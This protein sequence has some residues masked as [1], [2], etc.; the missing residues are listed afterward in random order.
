M[1]EGCCEIVSRRR[2]AVSIS[3]TGGATA[4]HEEVIGYQLLTFLQ[5]TTHRLSSPPT[6]S[7]A[8]SIAPL[9]SAEHVLPPVHKGSAHHCAVQRWPPATNHEE[10]QRIWWNG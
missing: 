8:P 2:A 1:G 7:P 6:D 4:R 5:L 3:S 10:R 9:S